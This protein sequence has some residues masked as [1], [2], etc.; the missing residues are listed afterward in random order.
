MYYEVMEEVM[1]NVKVVIL[2]S[3]GTVVS[4]FEQPYDGSNTSNEKTTQATA[5]QGG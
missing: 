1:P 2:D 5:G 4:V 3:N